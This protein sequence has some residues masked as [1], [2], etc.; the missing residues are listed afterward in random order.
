MGQY[1]QVSG[2]QM[3]IYSYGQGSVTLVLLSGSGVLFPQLE[4]M[5]LTQPLARDYHVVGVEKLGYGRSDL[6]D[7][8]RD[9][10]LAVEEYRSALREAG[11]GAQVVL[12]AHSMGF[13]EALRW[14]QLYPS[15]VLGIIGIDPA[16]PECYK[17]FDIEGAVAGLVALS[18]DEALCRE[19]A[20]AL[21][22]QIMQKQPFAPSEQMT[23]EQLALERLANENWIS[24]AKNLRADLVKVQEDGPYLQIPMLFFVSNGEGT[25]LEKQVWIHHALEY[26]KHIKTVRYELYDYPHNLYQFAGKEMAEQARGFIAEYIG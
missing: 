13:L 26:L 12:A 25:T 6:S 1:V 18:E 20:A 3:H 11:V 2:K 24:E 9:V 7:Q 5:A 14:G 10:D 23:L 22:D 16:T 19:T 4:Y 21:M 8:E 15:E 17:D